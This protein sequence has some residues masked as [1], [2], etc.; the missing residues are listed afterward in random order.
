MI[1]RRDIHFSGRVQGVGFRYNT[2]EIAKRFPVT[3]FVKNLT[4]GRVQ[5]L[6]EGEATDLDEVLD[7]IQQRM[8]GF[9]RDTDIKR[10]TPKG[11]FDVFEIR[12]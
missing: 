1:E 9:I 8:D 12:Y 3:G 4:D 5:M 2:R 7:R 6:V 10:G 11:E